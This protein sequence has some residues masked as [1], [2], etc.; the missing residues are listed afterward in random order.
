MSNDCVLEVSPKYLIPGSVLLAASCLRVR[1]W[2]SSKAGVGSCL[3]LLKIVFL[4]I[5]LAQE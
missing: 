2:S 3:A 1:T 5:G 4:L